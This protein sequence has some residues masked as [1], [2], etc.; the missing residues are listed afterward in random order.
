MSNAADHALVASVTVGLGHALLEQQKGPLT[1]APLLSALLAGF[2]GSLPDRIEPAIHPHHRQ[3]FHSIV[4]A[5]SLL[6]GLRW[7]YEQK[8]DDLLLKLAH[9]IGLT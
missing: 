1:P 5:M 9:G 6:Y 8:P 2:C 4:F 3:F 7:L